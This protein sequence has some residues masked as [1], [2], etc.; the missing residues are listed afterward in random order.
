MIVFEVFLDLISLYFSYRFL[1][2]ALGA[3]YSRAAM[4][5]FLALGSLY[6]WINVIFQIA[7]T[8]LTNV[9]Y[10]FA[11]C[12]VLYRLLYHGSL[13]KI[14]FYTLLLQCGPELASCM[15]LPLFYAFDG[16]FLLQSR[17]LTGV[18]CAVILLKGILLEYAGRKFPSLRNDLPAGYPFYLLMMV[19]VSASVFTMMDLALYA[20]G[21]ALFAASLFGSAFAAAGT[22]VL[23][24]MVVSVNRQLSL[25]LAEERAVLQTGYY[26]SREADWQRTVR[27][28]HDMKNHLLC[29]DGLL[30]EGKPDRARAYMATLVHAVEQLREHIHT[31]NDFVDAIVNEKHA[32]ALSV[33]AA[34]S[35]DM[36]LPAECRIS[37]PDLCCIFSN[38]LDNAIEACSRLEK[39]R[40]I[41]ARA[42]VRQGQL[43]AVLRNSYRRSERRAIPFRRES[44]HGYGLENVRRAV[45]K[46]G[47]VMELSA[48]ECFTFSVMIPLEG[49][50]GEG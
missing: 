34:F 2:R 7:K 17:I 35:A 16:N 36:A 24:L 40:W 46:Y 13:M 31:G 11:G 42:F 48:A 23:I 22:L 37:P 30:R 15:L 10:S 21:E 19:F 44:G 49:P 4:L 32:Q 25:R 14:A 47:G 12:L 50:G 39:D 20:A 33:G 41:E 27:F 6:G 28:R 9:L 18:S 5:L 43:V 38:A 1:N 3:K 26:K 29:L 8:I 45:E